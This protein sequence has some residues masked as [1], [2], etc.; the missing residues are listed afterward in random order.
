MW[1]FWLQAVDIRLL[2]GPSAASLP[3]TCFTICCLIEIL[4][5]HIRPGWL[6]KH[7]RVVLV[8]Y[9]PGMLAGAA[10]ARLARPHCSGF[11]IWSS[12]L[13]GTFRTTTWLP[14]H[15]FHQQLLPRCQWKVIQPST[16]SQ[17]C[18]Y[19]LGLWNQVG[20]QVSHALPDLPTIEICSVE[21]LHFGHF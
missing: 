18:C 6:L 4:P 9:C 2:Y 14:P 3:T 1:L 21:L 10:L 19:N 20:E 16:G 17:S 7:Q 12:P 11:H 5:S 8:D 13:P 15:N